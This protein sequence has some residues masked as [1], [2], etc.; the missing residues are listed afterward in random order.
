MLLWFIELDRHPKK[1]GDLF[2]RF[3]GGSAIK[4]G[5][6]GLFGQALDFG[7]GKH[8]ARFLRKFGSNRFRLARNERVNFVSVEPDE[9]AVLTDI[10]VNL[11]S[12]GQR[13]V[14]HRLSAGWTRQ[15][16][17]SLTSHRMQ[18]QWIDRFRRDPLAQQLDRH[19]TTAADIAT[20]ENAA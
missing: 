20:I 3:V 15:A 6:L 12:I 11:R 19:C 13:D 8:L 2:P 5:S 9:M 10:D 14:D 17:A 4:I 1:R 16:D 18:P 7:D